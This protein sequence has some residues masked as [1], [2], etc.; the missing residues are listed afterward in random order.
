MKHDRV[1]GLL[2]SHDAIDVLCV[3][4][5]K[6][7]K[8]PAEKGEGSA[9]LVRV[10]P[11]ASARAKGRHRST[12]RS[13]CTT[14]Q[15]ISAHLPRHTRHPSS[16]QQASAI[17]PQSPEPATEFPRHQRRFVRQVKKKSIR[18][19]DGRGTENSNRHSP[20]PRATGTFPRNP[21]RRGKS[22][23]R[24]GPRPRARRAAGPAKS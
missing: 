5:Q 19:P 24:A 17:S 9:A 23:R 7:K 20:P 12:H 8:N 16:P 1:M 18:S 4:Y 3:Y 10:G 22:S 21:P 14:L 6:K 2:R 13:P 15:T 11:W